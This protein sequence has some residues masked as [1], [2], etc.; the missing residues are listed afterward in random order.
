MYKTLS[1][2]S[3]SGKKCHLKLGVSTNFK[4]QLNLRREGLKYFGYNYLEKTFDTENGLKI[5]KK[6]DKETNYNYGDVVSG[7]R[8]TLLTC[9]PHFVYSSKLEEF[10]VM[11]DE[12]EEKVR[13]QQCKNE[14]G[15][16]CICQ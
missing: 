10:S 11:E 13:R 3:C 1:D 4:T 16:P 8:K 15:P 14:N 7:E 5:L 12:I 2:E 6:I 9:P